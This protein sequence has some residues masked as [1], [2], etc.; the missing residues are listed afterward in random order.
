VKSWYV[1]APMGIGKT[2]AIRNMLERECTKAT[3][4][5]VTFSRSL[6]AKLY[7]D[8]ERPTKRINSDRRARTHAGASRIRKLSEPKGDLNEDRGCPI[9]CTGD[10][11]QLSLRHPR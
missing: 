6:A 7:N 1:R 3:K 2:I 4:C 10:N 9:L 5:C 8:F 11:V